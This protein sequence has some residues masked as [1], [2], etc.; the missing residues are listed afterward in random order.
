MPGKRIKL[1]MQF[2]LFL[3]QS[4]IPMNPLPLLK[5]WQYI[6]L[7]PSPIIHTKTNV[8]PMSKNSL[9]PKIRWSDCCWKCVCVCPVK[10]PV[11]TFLHTWYF[12]SRVLG[13]SV[14]KIFLF[15][16][17]LKFNLCRRL[18]TVYKP[19]KFLVGS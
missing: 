4:V 7:N 16:A 2:I 11:Y 8:K 3:L 1:H 10:R 19:L 13:L 18:A 12:N 17:K 15:P 6:S 9:F 14:L 5:S